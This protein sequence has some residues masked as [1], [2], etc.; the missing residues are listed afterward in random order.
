[1][2]KIR[3]TVPTTKIVTFFE[4]IA[5]EFKTLHEAIDSMSANGY[6]PSMG[7]PQARKAVAEYMAQFMNYE[8]DIV[9]VALANGASGALEFAISAIADR[10]DNILLPRFGLY[11]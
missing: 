9:D 4:N 2:P 5:V 11:D 10:G 6:G 7:T 1:M 3:H 8:P